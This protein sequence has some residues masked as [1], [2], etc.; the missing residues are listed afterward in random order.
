MPCFKV[1]EPKANLC[2]ITETNTN[3]HACAGVGKELHTE[4]VDLTSVIKVLNLD[5]HANDKISK[6]IVVKDHVGFVLT[7]PIV[8]D[9]K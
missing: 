7:I 1:L 2:E 6:P 3:D 8:A 9:G 4:S 5:P